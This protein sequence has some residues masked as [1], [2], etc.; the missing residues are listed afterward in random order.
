[1]A[2]VS[3]KTVTL[4]SDIFSNNTNITVIDANF[5][6]WENNTVS[7]ANCTNLKYVK[8]LDVAVTNMAGAFLNCTNLNRTPILPNNV[9]DIDNA[10]E[11]CTSLINTPI[12]PNSVTNMSATFKGCANLV[13]VTT[14][15]TSVTIMSQTFD[16]CANLSGDIHILSE[17]ITN[18]DGI[19]NNT[20]AVKNVYINFT[21]HDINTTT[22][23][24][25]YA[26]GFRE[27][28]SYA[29]VYLINTTDPNPPNSVDVTGYTYSVN[30]N[31][32]TL[33]DAPVDANGEV[34]FPNLD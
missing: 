6:P 10:F 29:N 2:T 21:H 20:T 17:N 13:G 31:V 11:N 15:P 22:F 19:F 28:G 24:T 33:L 32:V 34:V 23:N 5:V 3:T 7:F 14:I 1:M 26:A 27:D 9:V 12:I 25:F 16:G 30:N 18:V 8:N 4:K